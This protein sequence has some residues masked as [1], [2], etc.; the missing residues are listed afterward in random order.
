MKRSI[1]LTPRGRG[2]LAVAAALL[3][4]AYS[5]SSR[6]LLLSACL[7][8]S[9]VVTAALLA[10]FRSLALD[11]TRT[12]S[13]APVAATVTTTVTIETRNLAR[14]RSAPLYWN[15]TLP[16]RPYATDAVA[17]GSIPSR[18]RSL[19]PVRL[20]YDLTPPRRGIYRVGPLAVA[21][22]DPF[23]IAVGFMSLGSDD[24]LVVTPLVAELPSTGVWLE[25]PDGA[26]R[27]V[28]STSTGNTDDLM[29]REYRRGDALRRVH[30]RA[31][32]RHGELM[33]RQ[34][35]QR[36]FPEA[37]IVIDSR[38]HGYRDVHATLANP[39]AGEFSNAFE[40]AVTMLA[41]LGVH[42]H[43][44]GFAVHVRESSAK[45]VVEL[46]ES[47]R[48]G[49]EE[50]FL[51]S[52]ARLSLSDASGAPEAAAMQQPAGPV[53]ALISEPDE[54]TLSWLLTL[55]KPFELGVVFVV[56]ARYR[57]TG[58]LGAAGWRVIPVDT[59]TDPLA[60]W[61]LLAEELGL[62]NALR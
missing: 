2:F 32:A 13:P 38:S 42:L 15:D 10:R 47:A 8:V 9:L 1:R 11:V 24:E 7:L 30:W 41:S 52:L 54:A 33:V 4:V 58:E 29:T 3:I 50:E 36:A 43:R 59:Y 26:A 20:E 16:W 49:T 57:V 53:F 60:A 44:S 34:E 18:T 48:H 14:Q 62:S 23:G 6:L 31:S 21:Y 39:D 27:L 12:F 19:R 37:T 22:S 40:W 61:A 56:G 45:Q 28:Q 35:E 5:A 46:D 17:L 55:R 25:A 51:L